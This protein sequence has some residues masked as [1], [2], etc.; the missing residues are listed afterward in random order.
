MDKLNKAQ[1][2]EY[3]TSYAILAL[4]DGNVSDLFNGMDTVGHDRDEVMTKIGW[5]CEYLT[6]ARTF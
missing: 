5:F 3:A 6:A 4:Y 2:D 1:K